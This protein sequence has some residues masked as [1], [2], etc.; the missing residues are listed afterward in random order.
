MSGKEHY[1]ISGNEYW[2]G[3]LACQKEDSLIIFLED[4]PPVE[5]ADFLSQLA[6][7]KTLTMLS[8]LSVPMQGAVFTELDTPY[9]CTLYRL[10]E[11]KDFAAI[12]SAMPSEYR[13]DFYQ[14]LDGKEQARLLPYLTKKVREDVIALIAYSPE[15]AGSIMSTDF[16]TVL[17]T[18]TVRQAI[19]K[20]KEDAPSKKMIYYI[21]VVDHNM[22]M[23][24]FV[25]LKDL[26][27]ADPNELV[28]ESLHENFIYAGVEDDQETVAKKIEKYALVAMPILNEEK[29]LV[30]IVSYD[31]AMEIIR[32]EQT[33]DM[34]RFMGI[35]SHEEAS[36]YLQVSSFQHYKRRVAW[37]MGLFIM[38][39]LSSLVIHRHEYLLERI[40][41][42][43]LY[44][45][46]I[47]AT[48]G[49]AGSQSA[50]VIVR[51]LSL[52]QISLRNWLQVVLKEFKVAIFLA[53]SLF[54][55]AFIKV[56]LLSGS[57]EVSQYNVFRVAF[58]IGLALCIQVINSTI[59]GAVL[60]LIAKYFNG[61]P[62]VA[63]SPAITTIVDIIGMII[64]F[65]VAI[66][67]LS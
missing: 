23:L 36:N 20:L 7:T 25:S 40:T 31:Y 19:Q 45:P 37:I 15:T 56:L 4:A 13:A 6:P 18:M 51:A 30:G 34:E 52:G 11:K 16:S 61:D 67:M 43:S 12:F 60:P 10:V 32:L 48:G 21:Y 63:A 62:A 26:V 42:L 8:G 33:E 58:T 3:L 24:G 59:I 47:A 39:F 55:L 5:V 1:T 65:T 22:R 2:R 54:V 38:G 50:S 9:Q 66:I 53:I 46:M 49:N 17:E 27:M 29:Q 57:S 44:L 35:V 14:Q 64:Y 28:A 41:I